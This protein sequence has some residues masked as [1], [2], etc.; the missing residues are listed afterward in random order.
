MRR[1]CNPRR[2]RTAS[3]R[4]SASETVANVM[5]DTAPPVACPHGTQLARRVCAYRGRGVGYSSAW[6]RCSGQSGVDGICTYVGQ[7]SERNSAIEFSSY[8]K[9][10]FPERPFTLNRHPRCKRHASFVEPRKT[11][12]FSL[13]VV[14]ET[15]FSV[16]P[17]N[18][19][20]SH[21]TPERRTHKK[22]A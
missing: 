5:R 7:G 12:A 6:L 22:G 8:L 9:G 18:L 15:F 14:C 2:Y 20:D 10:N 3:A 21:S 19:D 1:V 16:Y 4:V 11:A 17:S 13:K